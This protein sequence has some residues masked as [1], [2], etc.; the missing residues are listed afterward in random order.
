MGSP[1]MFWGG[2]AMSLD[3]LVL[4]EALLAIHQGLAQLLDGIDGLY[5]LKLLFPR[6]E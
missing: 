3:D 2:T 6:F 1:H 5:P 4:V